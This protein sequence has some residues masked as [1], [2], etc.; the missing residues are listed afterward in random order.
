NAKSSPRSAPRRRASCLLCCGGDA[1]QGHEPKSATV[2]IRRWP[3]LVNKL[4]VLRHL[5]RR[6]PAGTP[7]DAW[8]MTLGAALPARRHWPDLT[9]TATESL[10]ER[11]R[12]PKVVGK[13]L[14]LFR[15]RRFVRHSQHGGRINRGE[16]RAP[17]PPAQEAAAFA[18][19]NHRPSHQRAR[20][21]SP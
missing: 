20:R 6:S 14:E 5:Q 11:K 2:R 10:Y 1:R 17:I 13:A 15:A 3:F 16:P 7:L 21:R 18:R 19:Q 9:G 12:Q 4:D 8:G